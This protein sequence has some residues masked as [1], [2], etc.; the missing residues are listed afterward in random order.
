MT[1]LPSRI[2]QQIERLTE[3]G[4]WVWMGYTENGYARS[5]NGFVHREVYSLLVGP[6]P[7][8]LVLD[9]LCRVRC[10][11]NP[12]HL[13]P[14][15][16]LENVRRGERAQKKFCKRGHSLADAR[17]DAK[18]GNRSCRECYRLRASNLNWRSQ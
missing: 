3:C 17:I 9:H 13:E 12:D 6:I 15:T 10:C 11:L 4:C 1:S 14:V 8:G 16:F 5:T 18:T 2:E 7:D